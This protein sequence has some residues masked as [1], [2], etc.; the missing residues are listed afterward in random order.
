MKTLK[1]DHDLAQL[2]LQGKKNTTWRLYD[3]KDLAVDDEIK[4]IDKVNPDEPASWKV[5]GQAQVTQIIEKKLKA[6][7]AADMR[8]HEAFDS[9]EQMLKT[10]QQYYGQRVNLDT[11]VKI[12]T[13]KFSSTVGEVPT[14]SMLLDEA[15]I[16]TDGGSRGNPGDSA[17]AFVICNVDN[18]VVEKSGYYLGM[19]TNNQAEY[20]GF[21]KALE[22]ASRLGIDKI[23]L[24]SD[25]Q[26]VVNQM[27]GLY[28]VRNQELSPLHQEATE[29]ANSFGKISFAYIPR[30]LNKEA[31]GEV[32][33][34]LDEHERTQRHHH[35]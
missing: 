32:N 10:Y 24:F 28:K 15:K 11:N 3:D 6:I 34:I 33:R 2:I 22:R 35:K 16:Y 8:G 5:I 7:T 1:F 17:C 19:A 27:K 18:S 30:E 31:D 9:R 23:S 14:K 29:L 25:S 12:V 13:F 4:I 20:Y 26:L 21:I